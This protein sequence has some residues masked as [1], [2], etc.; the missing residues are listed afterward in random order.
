[1]YYI[2]LGGSDLFTGMVFFFSDNKF[3]HRFHLD[4]ESK[5]HNPRRYL[6]LL[7]LL[8]FYTS[9]LK[10]EAGYKCAFFSLLYFSH[11]CSQLH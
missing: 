8:L 2:S 3:R 11:E 7:L 4:L 9:K 6:L 1:M 5:F 10:T